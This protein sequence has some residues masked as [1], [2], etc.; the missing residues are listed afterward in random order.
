MLGELRGREVGKE[1]GCVLGSS[2]TVLGRWAEWG[3]ERERGE[4]VVWGTCM[5]V[6]M[7]V[8]AASHTF[9]IP[10]WACPSLTTTGKC[11]AV[12]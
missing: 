2:N 5:S 9:P 7:S 3:T 12:S 6:D 1:R 8:R 11:G 4:Q 10:A